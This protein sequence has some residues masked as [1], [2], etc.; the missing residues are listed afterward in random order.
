[1]VRLSGFIN[2]VQKASGRCLEQDLDLAFFGGQR[3][4]A[5]GDGIVNL[6][7][8]GDKVSGLEIPVRHQLHHCRI[9]VAIADCALDR[10]LSQHDGIGLERCFVFPDR[11]D[12][13]L[14][15][16]AGAIDHLRQNL[17]HAGHLEGDVNAATSSIADFRDDI[18]VGRVIAQ[19]APSSIALARRSPDGSTT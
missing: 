11:H 6:D 3:I 9:D 14:A 7:P 19:V 17:R 4:K 10:A 12:Q 18:G 13:R 15:F 2:S 8:R 5:F 16:V 1:M